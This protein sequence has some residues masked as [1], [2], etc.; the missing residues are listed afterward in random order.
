MLLRQHNLGGDPVWRADLNIFSTLSVLLIPPEVFFFL[1]SPVCV[2][3][4]CGPPDALQM[5]VSLI[6]TPAFHAHVNFI[7]TDTRA[8]SAYARVH[9]PAFI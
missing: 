1:P 4:A 6:I 9:G 3:G 5:S 7:V 8:F 2:L